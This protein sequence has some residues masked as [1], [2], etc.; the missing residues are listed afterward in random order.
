M[1]T[2]TNLPLSAITTK[3]REERTLRKK[4][5]EMCFTNRYNYKMRSL[6]FAFLSIPSSYKVP[7][8]HSYLSTFVHIRD[9]A[10]EASL[11]IIH[12]AWA[13]N[14]AVGWSWSKWT[15]SPLGGTKLEPLCSPERALSGTRLLRRKRTL[16]RAWCE[17]WY[18]STKFFTIQI[19]YSWY[20]LLANVGI[21][22]KTKQNKTVIHH[23]ATI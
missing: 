16:K 9:A 14:C 22:I 3:K 19:L 11:Q 13:F 17:P 23:Y 20:T 18:P 1:R 5:Y 6:K 8:G 4:N 7:I 15:E 12:L 10:F 2:H 21:I